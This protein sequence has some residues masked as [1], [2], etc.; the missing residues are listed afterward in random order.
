MDGGRE[1]IDYTLPH[2][3]NPVRRGMKGLCRFLGCLPLNLGSIIPNPVYRREGT[4][5]VDPTKIGIYLQAQEGKIVRVTSPYW[6]PD[7]PEWVMVTN[8][9]N[10]TLLA[11]RDII[12]SKGLMDDPSQ[13]VWTGLPSKE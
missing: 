9:A 4:K 5:F 1:S 6:I 13:V 2:N 11:A 12:K 10:A 8:D 3:Y 7:E